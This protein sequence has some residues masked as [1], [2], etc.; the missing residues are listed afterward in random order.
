MKHA[1]P[2]PTYLVHRYH[3]WKATSMPTIRHGTAT[4]PIRASTPARW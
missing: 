3:G 1:R 4:W 2:L